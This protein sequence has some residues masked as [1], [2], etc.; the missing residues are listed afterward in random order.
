M[1]Q[2]THVRPAQYLLYLLVALLTERQLFWLFAM[3]DSQTRA[4]PTHK[5]MEAGL[6]GLADAV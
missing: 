2:G 1:A 5:S 6:N 3:L 4:Q